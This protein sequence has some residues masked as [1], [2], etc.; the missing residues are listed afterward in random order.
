MQT[1]YSEQTRVDT[2]CVGDQ[3]WL[4]DRLGRG[5]WYRVL[6]VSIEADDTWVVFYNSLQAMSYVADDTVLVRRE[7]D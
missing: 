1:V 3:V 5:L 2:L 7:V 4:T 6:G